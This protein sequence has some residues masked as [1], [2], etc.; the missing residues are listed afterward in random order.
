MTVGVCLVEETGI[1]VG[2]QNHVTGSIHDAVQRVG[3]DIV[4]EKMD[5]LVSG[6]RSVRLTDGDG[7]ECN[8][9]PCCP[10]LGHNRAAIKQSLERG[11]CGCCEG[12]LKCRL[13]G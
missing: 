12:A 7:A 11:V 1:G 10:P 8:Q 4:E 6:N 13:L 5:C 2:A 3:S 9:K